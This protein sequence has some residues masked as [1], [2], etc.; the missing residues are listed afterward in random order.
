[1]ELLILAAAC[2]LGP[3]PHPDGAFV[4]VIG[5]PKFDRGVYA[6]P[7]H[8]GGYVAVGVT[9]SFGQGGEDV[10]L[11]KTDST[12]GL[13]WTRTFGGTGS[14]NGWAVHETRDGFILSGYTN[15]SGA[16]GYDFYLIKTN[17]TGELQWSRTYGGPGDDYCWALA[18][19]RDGGFVLVGETE[20]FGAGEDDFYLV[21]TDGMG[22]E[23]WSKTYGGSKGDRCFGVAPIE[24]GNGGYVLAGQTYSSGAGDRDVF[25][26]KTKANGDQDWSRTFGGAESDVGH[27][28]VGTSDGSFLVTGYTTS[29][30]TAGDDPYIIKINEDGRTHW[31]RVLS[32]EGSNH[33]LTGDEAT[34]GGFYLVGFSDPPAGG[35]RNALLV[36]TT[37]NGHLDWYRDVHPTS[38]GESFGYTVRATSDGGCV[39]TGHTTV[40]S[41]GGFDLLL[42]K[43]AGP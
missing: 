19:T 5:G 1:M 6:R 31:K 21:K 40:G 4:E 41:A 22:T 7:T 35:A 37:P 14:D 24:G 18:P 27:S 29:F 33:T 30:A 2:A 17:T 42:V 25:V 16:G 15:S 9:R 20:S 32:I 36:K 10:Y 8:D 13:L 28:I 3:F 11:V 43:A 39:F 38:S 23:Q 34:D 12:G 26:I